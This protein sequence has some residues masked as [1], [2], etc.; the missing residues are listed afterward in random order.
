MN[1]RKLNNF[2]GTESSSELSF[3]NV[4]FRCCTNHYDFNVDIRLRM[5]NN[6]YSLKLIIINKTRLTQQVPS[7]TYRLIF[8][9]IPTSM[10]NMN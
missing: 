3:E 7:S 5:Y 6:K 8:Y 4:G 2:S 9:D 10:K 1:K